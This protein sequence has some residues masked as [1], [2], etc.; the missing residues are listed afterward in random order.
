MLAVPHLILDQFEAGN[1]DIV[2]SP[3]AIEYI[4]G[5]LLSQPQNSANKIL[6]DSLSI[7]LIELLDSPY[8]EVSSS[9]ALR[10]SGYVTDNCSENKNETNYLELEAKWRSFLNSLRQTGIIIDGKTVPITDIDLVLPS[11]QC[12]DLFDPDCDGVI[13]SS[14]QFG[15]SLIVVIIVVLFAF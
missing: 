3:A 8:P 14:S 11:I 6:F 7:T 13:N 4:R 12:D 9:K 1:P 15:I 2:S 10:V 5:Q